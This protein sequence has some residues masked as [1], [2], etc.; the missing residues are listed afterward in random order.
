V[1]A[2]IWPL[3]D[4]EIGASLKSFGGDEGLDIGAKFGAILGGGTGG[5]LR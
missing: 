5:V 1:R 4:T 2:I 3:A